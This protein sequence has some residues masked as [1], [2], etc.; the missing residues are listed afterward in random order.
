[1]I[2]TND[3]LIASVGLGISVLAVYLIKRSKK[4]VPLAAASY[5]NPMP[6]EQ[7]KH[8][9]PTHTKET[10]PPVA[11][12]QPKKE[13]PFLA[14]GSEGK[15]VERLQIWLLRHHGWKGAVTGIY[16]EQTDRLVQK[17]FKK[18]HVD[19]ATYEKY[20]MGIPIHK[21]HTP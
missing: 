16:D 3:L 15:E 6:L 4:P 9:Q 1:M 17:R 13:A 21:L 11:E 5:H 8:S 19:K 20:Q 7:T 18:D 12:A 14:K 10:N 2:R